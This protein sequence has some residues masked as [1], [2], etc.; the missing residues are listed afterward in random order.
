MPSIA[1]AF[2]NL[3]SS[4]INCNMGLLQS[5][6]L[7]FLIDWNL[8]FFIHRR[9]NIYPKSLGDAHSQKNG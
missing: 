3:V 9:M 2:S 7:Q 6:N 8:A 4:S 1:T 5:L